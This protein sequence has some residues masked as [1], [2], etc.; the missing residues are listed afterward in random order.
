[1]HRAKFL[2]RIS[3]GIFFAIH[4]HTQI[5]EKAGRASAKLEGFFLLSVIVCR[6]EVRTT[7]QAKAVH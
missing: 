6:Y 3:Y 4:T 7:L 5:I 1:M 2:N